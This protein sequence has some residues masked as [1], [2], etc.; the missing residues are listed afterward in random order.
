MNEKQRKHYSF[1]LYIE[2]RLNKLY[3]EKYTEKVQTTCPAEAS[4]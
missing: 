1:I 4:K 2:K 3:K